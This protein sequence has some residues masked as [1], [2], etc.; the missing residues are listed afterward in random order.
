MWKVKDEVLTSRHDS[1]E[2]VDIY[3]N[4]LK[5]ASYSIYPYYWYAMVTCVNIDVRV[6]ASTNQQIHRST[7]NLR[8]WIDVHDRR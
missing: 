8:T 2:A 6:S 7:L 4:D 3:K 1:S 5:T